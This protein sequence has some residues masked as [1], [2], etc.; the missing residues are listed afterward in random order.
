MQTTPSPGAPS[1]A[2]ASNRPNPMNPFS[3]PPHRL[4]VLSAALLCLAGAARAQTYL[5]DATG[6]R[7]YSFQFVT[8]PAQP[9]GTVYS[10]DG[11]PA[12]LSVNSTTGV[13]SGTTGAVGLYKGNLHFALNAATSPYPYQITVDPAA[14]TPT[15]AGSGAA[16]G[17]VGTPFTLVIA[18]SNSPTSFNYA[19]L[20]PGLTSSGA[21]IS[22]TPTTAGLFFTSISGNNGNGQGAI[23]VFMFTIAAAGPLPSLTSAAL[24]SSAQGAA[25]SYTITATNSPTSFSA[26]GLPSGLSL[27]TS[28][29]L[30]SGTPAAP[31]VATILL[32]ASNS[33]GSSLPR[34]L[35]LTVGSFS[36]ITSP[37]TLAGTAGVAFAATLAASNSPV[38]FSLTGLPS[39]LSFNSV[40]GA[41]SGTP[42]TAGTYTLIAGATNA[43]GAGPSTVVTLSVAGSSGAAGSV[44]PQ[45]VAAPL[46]QSVTVGSTAAFSV[47]AAGSGTLAYQWAFNGVPIAGATSASLSLTLVNATEAGA[48]TVAVTNSAGTASSAPANLTVL[49]LFVPPAITAQPYM[50][51]DS[52]GS[53]VSFTVGASGT[54]PLTYQWLLGGAP[55]AGATSPTLAMLSVQPANAGIYSVVATNSAGSSTSTGALLT[56]TPGGVAP[57][58]QYQPSPTFITVGGTATLIVG[59][60]GPPSTSFQWY[61]GGIAIPGA[62]STSLTFSPVTAGNAG[63]YS[64]VI[65]D[66]AG[67]VTT[68]SVALT[69]NPAGGPPV[70]VSI[71][72]QPLPVSAQVGGLATFT[73]AVTGDASIAYQWRKNQSNI[74]GATGPS[75]SIVNVQACDGGTYDVVVSN[76]FS[77]AYSFP[78]PLTIDAAGAP[79]RLTN[80]SVRG[81]DGAAGNALIVGIVV[82]GTGT[83]SA[84]VRAVGPTLSQFGVT[85]LLAAPQLSLLNSSQAVVASDAAWGGTAALSAAFAQ[86][87]AFPLPPTSLDSAVL[88]TLA[89][90]S[91]SA[92]VAGA[93]GGTGV[94]LLEV[95]DADTSASPPTSF[96]DLSARG[97]S[98]TGSNV[99]TIGF[100]ITGPSSETVLVR[101]VG[102]T[103]GTAYSVA[104]AMANPSVTV[105]NSSQAV[106]GFDNV[107]GGTAA[108]QAAFVATGAFSLPAAS[109]DSAVL[110][111]LPPGAYTAQANSANGSTGIALLEVY[112]VP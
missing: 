35:V 98:G 109:A 97:M 56:V 30:I 16:T 101:A 26:I 32:A 78:T 20:P 73:V 110:L 52:A 83:K 38:T 112:A 55:I 63:V 71:V 29:G 47:A 15:I 17:T 61:D 27:N 45:I 89:P 46:S 48:Y 53:P 67:S 80:L 106:V 50:S 33:Y 72:L 81:L 8:N 5:P 77:A 88:A 40:T 11:L 49:S 65:T 87:G 21:Q 42:A 64:A 31:Q 36:A 86:T 28:T 37:A 10:A 24:V 58:F 92:Q 95:Y 100:V 105:Y 43:L 13:V 34:N 96:T 4:V 60:V 68:S 91:Y 51:T 93:N 69:V 2:P 85:G 57:I 108:L 107:W 59:V 14:G 102:P 103:L 1:R 12:G 76:G 44:A 9:A 23:V 54:A 7:P 111:T 90:G 18:A 3:I 25:V 6:G 22:G 82:A 94:V 99:L 62:T 70:P 104:G 74:A 19:Q 41:I 39:G 66:P 79:S 84:L 75:F